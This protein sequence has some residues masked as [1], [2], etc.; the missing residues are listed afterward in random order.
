MYNAFFEFQKTPFPSGPDPAFFY[1]SQ[2]HDASLRGLTFAVQA[3]LGLASLTGEQGTGKTLVLE[4][5][6]DSLEASQTPCAFL[7]DSRV[8]TNRL[9]EIIASELDLRCSATSADQVFSALREFT[10]QQARK[11][12][13]VA[14]IV[15]DA[16]NLSPEVFDEILRL[17]SLCDEKAKLLQIVLA[18]R[19]EL[20]T[21][22]DALNLEPLKQHAILSCALQPFTAGETEDY[23]EFHLAQAG[24]PKQTVFSPEAIAEIYDRSRGFAPAIH[25]VCE[26]LLRAAFSAR[27][28]VCTPRILDQVFT[29]RAPP[30]QKTT[31]LRLAFVAIQSLPPP[32]PVNANTLPELQRTAFLVVHPTG[33]GTPGCSVAQAG[34][35]VEG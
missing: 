35:V 17:A 5:L 12:R 13:T 10:L 6:R 34:Y 30:L 16:H 15:D 26:E 33:M 14:L 24:M 2:Q 11:R 22:L 32:L 18:G 7:R 29:E 3:R 31:L 8:S 27:S 21:T 20:D 4:C 25:T 19:P 23:I 28:R 1:R 9:F